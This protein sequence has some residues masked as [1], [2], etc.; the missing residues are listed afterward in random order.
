MLEVV[1]VKAFRFKKPKLLTLPEG[2]IEIALNAFR[3]GKDFS[4]QRALYEE[5]MATP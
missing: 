1:N 2:F 3:N 5:L 4:A